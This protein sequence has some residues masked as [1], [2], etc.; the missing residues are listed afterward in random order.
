IALGGDDVIYGD[1][2]CPR[3]AADISYCSTSE[4]A[5]DGGDD[6]HGGEGDDRIYGQ[7][8]DDWIHASEGDD[9]VD[10]GSG[11][12][13][14]WGGDGDDTIDLRDGE[15]DE[16][17]CGAGYDTVIADRVDQ[18]ARDCESVSRG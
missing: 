17:K 4:T 9:M 15:P 10:A 6:L 13:R 18:V 1:G 11:Y 8:G 2:T 12:D 7:G 16:V 14:V 3:G 5:S